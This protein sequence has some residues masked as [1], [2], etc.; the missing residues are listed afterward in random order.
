MGEAVTKH[1][2]PPSGGAV[3][4]GTGRGAAEPD[5]GKS[6][7]PGR[8]WQ[9]A[10]LGLLGVYAVLA[11]YGLVSKSSAFGVGTASLTSPSASAAKTATPSPAVRTSPAP[12]PSSASIS[13]AP[14]SLALRSVVAFGPQGTQDGDNSAIASR[15]IDPSTDQPWYSR[16]Y[17][18]PELG[19]LQTGTGLLID[20]GKAERVT[21]VRLVLGTEPGADIQVRVGESPSLSMRA[22]ASATRV[23]GKVRLAA[24]SPAK[25]RYVLIWFTRLP[26]IAD[27]HFQISVYNVDVD[28]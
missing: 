17:A 4:H 2:D 26:A 28:G 7:R 15:L 25:G 9:L 11:A 13:P 27:G 5:P 18:T 14:H 8:K 24:T 10:L 19:D 16:W 20:L 21:D 12:A 1:T 23:G 3:G 22:V 6:W